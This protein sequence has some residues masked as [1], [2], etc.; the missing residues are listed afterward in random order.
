LSGNFTGG[1]P[2]ATR[3]SRNPFETSRSE[4]T[5]YFVDVLKNK[6]TKNNNLEFL[7]G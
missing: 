3:T 2:G 5:Q 6:R 4:K 7:V 1:K